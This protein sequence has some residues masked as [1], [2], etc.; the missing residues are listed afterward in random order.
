MKSNQIHNLSGLVYGD[1][2]KLKTTNELNHYSLVQ[3]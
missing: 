3:F 2:Q 1:L